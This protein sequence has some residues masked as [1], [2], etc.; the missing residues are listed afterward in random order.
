MITKSFEVQQCQ[1][2]VLQLFSGSGGATLG[3]QRAKVNWRG[4]QGS[5]KTLAGI[6]V[7][8]RACEN[9]EYLTGSKAVCMD[10]FDKRDY[11]AFHGH[12]PLSNWHEANPEDLIKTTNGE[13][14]DL[15]FLSPPCK[16]FSA[17]LSQKTSE[18]ERY[19]A[20]NRLVVR[21]IFLTLEAFKD[22]L[23]AFFFLENVPRI[24]TRG[25]KL[26]HTITRML[27]SYGYVV[28]GRSHDLGE[29]AGLAQHRK[30]YLLVARNPRKISTFLYQPPKQRIKS[31]GEILAKVPLPDDLASGPL[32]RLPRLQ[33]KTWVR[34][35]LIPA[36]GDW[37]DLEEIAPEQYRL[38]YVPRGSGP[39]GV[40][41][42]EGPAATVIGKASVKG[43]NAAAIADPRLK[44][45]EGRHAC[46][47]Q[48]VE[49]DEP[50]KTVTGTRFGSGASAISDPRTGFKDN[51][52]HIVYKVNK[53]GDEANTVT[54][55]YRP[56]NGAMSIEDPRMSC[57]PR[58]GT[59]GV[60]SW[61][62][63]AKTVIGA[64]DIHAGSAA[65]ADPRI[66]KDNETLDPPPIIISLDG[67][68]H[69]PLTTL[70]LAAIQGLP[71]MVNGKPLQFS[72]NSDAVWRE[73]IGNMVP[74]DAG[75]VMAEQALYAFMASAEGV[76]TMAAEGI[77]V[78]PEG[79]MHDHEPLNQL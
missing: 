38:E 21:G 53:W 28:N 10:L 47:Y 2:K 12:E 66:P 18:T 34:L 77:W 22:D 19:Q 70:E 76:W 67:T 51:T 39:F 63:P 40:L 72:G 62:E 49:W 27:E 26:L 71:L 59:M 65:I 31:I 23:P 61:N 9:Y 45:R 73:Q 1:W 3:F 36:G 78:A 74:P 25:K 4:M 17:L 37:R 15:V 52:H 30:R 48:V 50:A 46:V 58:S 20:L 33:W 54:G 43:S 6:D 64:G 68:W 55:A 14:P 79:D 32:H 42:W 35:A 16:G 44:P 75:Q 56:N 7:D 24:L 57:S 60:T 69:R 11:V 5:F 41:D 29:I 8:P 13:Y